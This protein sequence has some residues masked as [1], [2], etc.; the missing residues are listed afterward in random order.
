MDRKFGSLGIL[1]ALLTL[2]VPLIA[3]HA[4]FSYTPG[5]R[6]G[7]WAKYKLLKDSCSFTDQ[8]ICQGLNA[9]GLHNS[10]YGLLQIV[11]VSGTVVDFTEVSVYLNGTSSRETISADI[12]N[13]TTNA[14]SIGMG[15]NADFFVL[16]ANLTTTDPIWGAGAPM[17]PTFNTTKSESVL[18]VSR[19][20]NFLNHTATTSNPLYMISSKSGYA[21]DKISGLFVEISVSLIATGYVSGEF[22]LDLAMIDNNIWR[23]GN[24]PDYNLNANPTTV[25]ITGSETRTATIT[26][27]RSGGFSATI[28][29]KETGSASGL[30]CSL[31]QNSLVQGTSDS[32]TLLCAGSPGSYTLT[33]QGNGSYTIRSVSVTINIVAKPD[34]TITSSGDF[35]FQTGS[36]GT[37]KIT[38]N[39]MNGYGA[40]TSLEVSS[41]PSGLTCSLSS[42]SLYGGESSTLT[43]SGQPGTYTVTVK[44]TG[45]GTSHTASTTVTVSSATVSPQP[46]SPLNIPLIA[47]GVVALLA[48]LLV[49]LLLLRR[50]PKTPVMELGTPTQPKT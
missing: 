44:A 47:G 46:A 24:I 27:T 4:A 11:L 45:G 33:V 38:L 21:F 29:L 41:T 20:V 28:A 13:G 10:D 26:P 14:T 31:S 9:G 23:S 34:F 16:A 30:T 42:S 12:L 32:A 37:A 50:R 2:S 35:T 6:Q 17:T 18:G 15:S 3:A 5:V 36:S 7:Q 43:C 22:D 8:T 19:E 39:A 48:V 40:A 25:S 49:V 1:L